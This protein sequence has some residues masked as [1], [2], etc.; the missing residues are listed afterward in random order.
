MVYLYTSEICEQGQCEK[1][2][3]GTPPMPGY[4]GGSRCM[5]HCHAKMR[6]YPLTRIHIPLTEAGRLAL[7]QAEKESAE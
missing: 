2:D 3:G 1:C 5:C 6:S 7:E 4:M